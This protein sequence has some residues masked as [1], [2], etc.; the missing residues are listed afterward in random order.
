MDGESFG[1]KDRVGNSLI[2]GVGNYLIVPHHSLGNSVIVNTQSDGS[3]YAPK[4][5]GCH[6]SAAITTWA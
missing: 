4:G 5:A 6:R 3:G 1:S 2:E